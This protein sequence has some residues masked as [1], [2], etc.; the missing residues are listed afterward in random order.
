VKRLVVRL[1]LTIPVLAPAASHGQSG[2]VPTSQQLAAI[3]ERGRLLA[4]YDVAAWYATDAVLPLRPPDDAVNASVARQGADGRWVVSFGR[5]TASRDTFYRAYEAVQGAD[6]KTFQV[7]THSPAEPLV[8]YERN[9]TVALRTGAKAFGVVRRPYNGYALP[10]PN[11]EWWVYFLPAQTQ[12]GVYPHGG[13]ARFRVSA[14]GTRLLETRRMHNSILESPMPDSVVA[15]YHTAV[16]DY[17]P[18][19]SD[20]FLVLRR[21][22]A[23]PEYIVSECC[24]YEVRIDGT[25]TWRPRDK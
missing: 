2:P 15:G 4:A 18:E 11:G 3:T 21:Q 8:G 10:T 6:P 22:P 20:V 19:D 1:L 13:D 25:I 24:Y 7:I 17:L 12:A 16:L 5:L 14:D 23:R 9:A